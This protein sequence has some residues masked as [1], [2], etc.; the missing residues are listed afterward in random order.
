[1][2]RQGEDE[3]MNTEGIREAGR[4]LDAEVAERVMG[5]REVTD[6]GYKPP[7]R[8]WHDAN[9]FAASAEGNKLSDGQT[10]PGFSP[11]TKIADAWRVVE[12]MQGMTP[13]DTEECSPLEGDK[14]QLTLTMGDDWHHS[15]M[16]RGYERI[17]KWGAIFDNGCG[18]P[19]ELADTAAHAICLAA[20]KAL[21]SPGE[22]VSRTSR[23]R[24]ETP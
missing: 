16:V 15:K 13:P 21:A 11:S 14:W 23:E 12:K 3:C 1:M 7:E 10:L 18:G 24:G 5:W 19:Y 22:S 20:L 6:Y 4:E 2:S 9:G 8:Q 17:P